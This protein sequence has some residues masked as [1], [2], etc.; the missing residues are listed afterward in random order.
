MIIKEQL[1]LMEVSKNQENTNAE[2]LFLDENEGLTYT[3]KFNKQKYDRNIKKFV[4]SKEQEEQVDKWLK[5]HLDCDYDTLE[6]AIGTR[7]DVYV[8]DTFCSLWESTSFTKPDNEFMK[9]YRG[10][11]DTT[12]D[13][14]TDDGT[15]IRIIFKVDNLNYSSSNIE[16]EPK[17]IKLNYSDWIASRQQF[18]ANGMK[19]KKTYDDFESYF[20]IP[21]SMKEQLIGR[22]ITVLPAKAGNNVYLTFFMHEL[23]EL[24]N[25]GANPA[26]FK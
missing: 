12:I 6:S 14:V 26:D 22:K 25:I 8:Y 3:V 21:I 17:G 16:C 18:F 15:R 23:N 20:N 1:E 9:K 7:K 13:N 11:V 5:E 10:G 19:K 4:E 24:S 2:L